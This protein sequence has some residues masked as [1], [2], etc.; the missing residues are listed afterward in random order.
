MMIFK[1]QGYPEEGEILMCIVKKIL[2]HSIFVDLQEYKDKEGYIHISEIAP[3]RIRN[4][5]DYVKENKKI[6]CKVLDINREKGYI[7]LSLRRVSE[8]IKLSKIEEFKQEEKA[9]KILGSV[10]KKLGIT[11][12]DIYKKIGNKIVE[13][14]GL[15][16]N[17]LQDISL[18]GEKVLKNLGIPH[19]ISPVL[20]QIVK[21]KIKQAEVTVS[22][23]ILL[24]T[25]EPDGI[26]IIKDTLKKAEDIAKEKGY[27]VKL[28]YIS[29]PKYMLAV[30]SK[31]YKSC[32]KIGLELG[33]AIMAGIKSRGH[34]SVEEIEK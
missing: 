10:A 29:A 8:S 30:T 6:V 25:S 19:D 34:G 16:N 13:S 26:S 22:Y 23:D 32:E 3:G 31:D 9:E 24:S 33:N 17:F 2:P 12:E 20:L 7:D 14:Y 15:I 1:K 5:R 4:I 11:L 21:E 28:R 18:N 27:E